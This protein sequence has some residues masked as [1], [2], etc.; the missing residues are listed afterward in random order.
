MDSK[1]KN[2]LL[3]YGI[4]GGLIAIV[5]LA[6]LIFAFMRETIPPN[7][8]GTIGNTPGNLNNG[9][10]FCEYNGKVYF[11]NP[12]DKGSLYMMNA[13][14]SEVQKLNSMKVRNILAGGEFLYYFQLEGAAE[15]GFGAVANTHSL[16]RCDLNGTHATSITRDVV[17]C[18]QLV[19]DYLYLLTASDENPLF[20]KIKIDKSDMVELAKY[21]I[22]PACAQNGIIYYNG[23]QDNHALYSLNTAN[24]V[25]NLIWSG[26]LWYP[27]IDGE[28][29]YYMDLNNNYRLGRYHLPSHKSELLTKERVDCFNVRSGYIYYQ[30][31]D[32]TDPRLKCMY[33]DGTNDMTIAHGVY[34]NIQMTSQYVYFQE[35]N[36]EESLFHARLGSNQAEF[37][38]P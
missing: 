23:T 10:F 16:N 14:E 36:V 9:G 26:N 32:A 7:P 13:D 35:F 18:G 20:Y 27:V 33:T 15:N 11:S 29:I 1:K 8:P 6:L 28:Y 12:T 21:S 3:A 2:Q 22:N 37:F 19:N 34:N 5:F 30:T 17:V 25:A 38:T 24:D 4:A 31:N